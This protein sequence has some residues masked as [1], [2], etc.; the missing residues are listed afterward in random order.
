MT[1]AFFS[2]L[3]DIPSPLCLSQQNK[4]AH[5]VRLVWLIRKFIE[6]SPKRFDGALRVDRCATAK[7]LEQTVFAK[8]LLAP[9][10]LTQSVRVDQQPGTAVQNKLLRRVLGPQ[11][12]SQRYS[13]GLDAVD[14]PG[15]GYEKGRVVPCVDHIES[16]G[17][18]TEPC[19]ERRDIAP[20]RLR[21]LFVVE[22]VHS[23]GQVEQVDPGVGHRAK[24]CSERDAD[25]RGRKA[26]SGDIGDNEN[27][28]A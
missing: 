8:H 22:A 25:Q 15:S 27:R 21:A 2:N 14:L 3:S 5:V 19:Q 11:K 17:C 18:R 7:H 20:L 16:V 6:S 1:P 12:K 28:V 4:G 10:C 23:R 26:L 24:S 13:R 9:A